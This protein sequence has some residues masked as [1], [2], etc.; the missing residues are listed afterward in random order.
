[1]NLKTFFL[2]SI[3]VFMLSGCQAHKPYDP[4]IQENMPESFSG[5]HY[6]GNLEPGQWWEQFNDPVLSRLM[7][8]TFDQN[9]DIRQAFARVEQMRAS[10][11]M[12]GAT[13]LPQVDLEASGGRERS[14]GVRGPVVQNRFNLSASATFEVDVWNKLKLAH[15]S[16][17]MELLASRQ[18]LRTLYLSLSAE[19]AENYYL[20]REQQ[21]QEELARKNIETYQQILELAELKYAQGMI[22][23]LDI[24][25]TKQNLAAA[26]SRLSTYQAGAAQALNRISIIT[27]QFPE[28]SFVLSESGLPEI[29]RKIYAGLPS[30]LLRKRPDLQ[31][32]LLR[33]K[34]SDLDVGQ[35]VADRF[36]SFRLA[37]TYGGASQELLNILDSPNIFW[38]LLVQIAQPILDGGQRAARVDARKAV[39]RQNLAA[40]YQ[41]V[42]EA[43]AEV[44]DALTLIQKKHQ[45]VEHI[46]ARTESASRS[47]ELSMRNY[48]QG[49]IDLVRVFEAQRGVYD[50]QGSLL[51]SRRELVS[52]YVQLMRALGGEWMD[53]Y[54]KDYADKDNQQGD[55]EW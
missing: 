30:D 34:S 29:P 2:L 53:E 7:Q 24:Y 20:A 46:K 33:L 52:A 44:E 55:R 12:A 18:D 15:D 26:R 27:G 16:A 6:P 39:F 3:S 45:A 10:A 32:A 36:P 38:N 9:L 48:A 40:Y 50:S 51:S 8:K 4:Q 22:S 42:L 43:C 19:L 21:A 1:M 11:R 35:A 31:A 41:A 5:A 25:Q 49:L 14:S 54:V 23:S 47:L 13:R 28:N 17:Q 37:G